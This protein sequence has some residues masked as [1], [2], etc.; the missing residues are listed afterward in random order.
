MPEIFSLGKIYY[1]RFKVAAFADLDPSFHRI[2]SSKLDEIHFQSGAA[3]YKPGDIISQLF[4]VHQG[5]V[6]LVGKDENET[7]EL[8][9]SK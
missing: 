8:G 7:S 9:R 2:L 5:E 6:T 1:F 4:I 3:I